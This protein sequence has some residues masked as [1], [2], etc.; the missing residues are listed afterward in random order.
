MKGIVLTGT[1]KAKGQLKIDDEGVK[2]SLGASL[3][4]GS[5]TISENGTAIRG[6]NASF[7]TPDL[8]GLRSAP[9]QQLTFDSIES[10]SMILSKGK[11]IY[12][13]GEQRFNAGG[14]GQVRL[15]RRTYFQQRLS[16]GSGFR[17]V[18]PHPLLPPN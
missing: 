17:R 16:G 6:I 13:L 1:I 2:S 4:N 12:Q 9:A 3:S 18:R 5:L 15:V 11:I 14:A 10:G 7:V 8:F